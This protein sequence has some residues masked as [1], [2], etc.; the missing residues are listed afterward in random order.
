MR[1]AWPWIEH[2]RAIGK[3][4]WVSLRVLLGAMEDNSE[5]ASDNST[6]ALYT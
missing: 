5:T 1:P 6:F 4:I 2:E 3:G